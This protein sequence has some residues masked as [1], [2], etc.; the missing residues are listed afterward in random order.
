MRET[1]E[2]AIV[3]P[4]PEDA[5]RLDEFCDKDVRSWVDGRLI[6]LNRIEI[7]FPSEESKLNAIARLVKEAINGS[8]EEA[9]RFILNVI[10]QFKAA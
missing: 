10:D 9:V 3:Q 5:L 1:R 7:H 4:R 2:I 8:R 6:D